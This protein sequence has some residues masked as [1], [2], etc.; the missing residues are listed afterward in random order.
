MI[1]KTFQRIVNPKSQNIR[2]DQYLFI[3][4]CGLS[5]TKIREIIEEGKVLVNGRKVKP[6]YRVKAGDVIIAEFEV[7]E[8]PDIIIPEE[9]DV[10]IIYEFH[11]GSGLL[12]GNGGVQSSPQPGRKSGVECKPLAVPVPSP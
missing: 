7:E 3:S 1:K 12:K 10:S 11:W 8:K 9:R 2:I 4:G 5:R 6:S